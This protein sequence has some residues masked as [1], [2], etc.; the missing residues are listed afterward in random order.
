MMIIGS[1]IGRLNFHVQTLMGFLTARGETSTDLLTIS[2]IG[3]DKCSDKTFV[4][5]MARNQG[6]YE[7]GKYTTPKQT[8]QTADNRFKNQKLKN[9][10]N[11]P[12]AEEESI[13][14]LQAEVNSMKRATKDGKKRKEN[15]K[16][17]SDKRKNVDKAPKDE[18]NKKPKWFFEEPNQAD[19]YKTRKWNSKDWYFCGP[20]SGE[21]CDGQYRVHKASACQGKAHRFDESKKKTRF[22]DESPS[23][24][25]KT[26]KL[27]KAL[28]DTIEDESSN[29]SNSDIKSEEKSS[30]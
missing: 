11:V 28:A 27:A 24:K 19:L 2:F 22:E 10:L 7:D 25:F 15:P 17:R 29:R 14:S 30:E 9:K 13:L 18:K 6:D 16:K 3:H 5:Y 4:A 26:M 12:S 23:K 20:A 21:K 8:M 1:D